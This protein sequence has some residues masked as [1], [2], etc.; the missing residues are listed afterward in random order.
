MDFHIRYPNCYI[1]LNSKFFQKKGKMRDNRMKIVVTGDVTI[2]WGI[3]SNKR[4][5][6]QKSNLA[7]SAKSN[8]F[9]EYGGAVFLSKLIKEIIN[10]ENPEAFSLI[11]NR[12]KNIRVLPGDKRF[13]HS[14]ALWAPFPYSTKKS[15]LHGKP[16]WRIT[17]HLGYE[18]ASQD[19]RFSKNG[20]LHI[21]NDDPSAEI[22]VINDKNLGFRSQPE[23]WPSAIVNKGSKPWIILNTAA[24]LVHG[25]LW[26]LLITDHRERLIVV[27]TIDDLRRSSIQISNGLSWESTAQDLLWELKNNPHI[28][29]ICQSACVIISLNAAGAAVITKTKGGIE[30][31]L[32]FDIF[33]LEDK[34]EEQYPGGM[35]GYSACMAAAVTHEIMTSSKPKIEDYINGAHKGVAALRRLQQ[36]GYSIKSADG[37]TEELVCPLKEVAEEIIRNKKVVAQTTIMDPG[38]IPSETNQKSNENETKV[39]KLWTIVDQN[40]AGTLE[41]LAVNIVHS[42]VPS[43]VTNFPVK[44]YGIR[45]TMDRQEIEDLHSIQRLLFEYCNSS[46]NKPLS[47]AVFGPPGTGKSFGIKQIAKS[48]LSNFSVLEFNISQFTETKNLYDAFHQIRDVALSGKIPLVFWDEFDTT[49][50]SQT[51]GW[52]RFFL[53]PMQD[54]AF[55]E[56]QITH[57]LGRCIFI[58]AGGTSHN[59]ESF[60]ID[61]SENDKQLAKLPDFI[62][63]LKGFL[64]VMGINPQG[65]INEDP[66]FILRR[67]IMLRSMI[68]YSA[69]GII[70]NN[71][72]QMDA[73]ILR[74]FLKTSIYKHGVRSMESIIAM[75]SLTNKLTYD[76]SSLPPENQ[77]NL[78]VD[79]ADFLSLVQEIELTGNLLD[80]LAESFHNNFCEYLKKQGYSYGILTDEKA[81]KHSSLLPFEQLPEDEKEQNRNNVRHIS[82]KLNSLGLIMRPARKNETTYQLL[83]SEVEELAMIEHER[84]MEQKNS[85]GW[86]YDPLTDKAG[87]KHQLLLPWEE[88]PESEKEKDRILVRS[89]PKILAN[90]GYAIEKFGVKNL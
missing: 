58:F 88:L 82:T 19:S 47:I 28:N 60:G 42:G 35:H 40:Q 45:F 49:F 69:P 64:N 85:D 86:K 73:G 24:P 56:E 18:T 13:N 6:V 59:M 61:L 34:W 48:V 71:E 26:K 15:D 4:S 55:Q 38:I 12:P 72:V 65:N 25:G 29:D 84:W 52:L 76:R 5:K 87:K 63:R 31:S 32:L 74:A 50:N 67:A 7:D 66:Y 54:G 39:K 78:H 14:Y 23:F 62:S 89:I 9:S 44:Q 33:N 17:E 90:A 1:L 21:T 3:A 2:D 8:S 20:V 30:G 79:A 81:K 22:V 70:K 10:R 37:R 16:S 11:D 75:S 46:Q 53:A 36:D 57:P 68:E 77:L 27:T 51:Y 43:V 83:D 41:N 80:E